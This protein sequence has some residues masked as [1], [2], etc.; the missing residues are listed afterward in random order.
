MMTK[1]PLLLFA[2]TLIFLQPAFAQNKNYPNA[3]HTKLVFNDFGTLNDEDF[4]IGQ[5]FEVGYFRNVAPFLNLGVPLK[6]G[7]AN[8]P[9]IDGNTVISSADLVAQLGNMNPEAKISPYAF[10]GV[11]Y[12][13]EDFQDGHVQFPFGAGAN[14]RISRY[15]FVNAQL[16]MR[17]AQ[18][19]LRD[20][21]Q[22]G[23][24][25][26]FLLHK[27]EPKVLP[28]SDTDGD[29]TP[30]N[31]DQCP[32]ASGPAT[33][34]GCPDTDGDGV[35]DPNDL[36]PEQTGL[37]EFGGCPDTDTDGVPD[38]DDPCPTRAGRLNGCPDADN[39]GIADDDDACPNQAGPASN[40]GCPQK[41]DKDGDGFPDEEDECPDLA[42]P[43]GGCPDTDGDGL[44]DNLDK[45]PTTAGSMDNFGCPEVKKETKE[46]L[47]YVAKN[48]QFETGSA[49]LTR[50]SFTVL[51]EV[52]A[53][54]QQ[55]P[56]YKM[57][58]SGHTDYTG[59][60]EKNLKLSQER[61]KACNDYLIVKGIAPARLRYAGFGDTR[62]V[63]DN[64]TAK[65]RELNRRV[66]FELTL[67]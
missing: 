21:L 39:D 9:G 58:I 30:D 65:G 36:C 37:A 17:V 66:E 63:A 59:N 31:L 2:L 25:F 26:V 3:I 20:N 41:A 23:V 60:T 52:F 53:I 45:C 16:E 5:G 46:R 35:I 42:G 54:L 7:L 49:L 18:E 22:L 48:V 44:A 10:G 27:S 64:A 15:A 38:K 50:N 11:G 67:E 57:S 40:K 28:P 14:F 8:I 51:D 6:L 19:E 43:F 12:F 47:A 24:G 34:F 1:L 33:T 4:H 29:G 61:A 56:D 62:P 32:T 13:L 55:Y